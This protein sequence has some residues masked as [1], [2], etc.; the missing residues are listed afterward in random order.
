MLAT[1]CE[2]SPA[3]TYSSARLLHQARCSS[4]VNASPLCFRR[5]A[6]AVDAPSVDL[7]L[8]VSVI[9]CRLLGL[10]AFGRCFLAIRLSP[11]LSSFARV[12]QSFLARGFLGDHR[13]FKLL[14]KHN[15]ARR[16]SFRVQINEIA[17]VKKTR[18]PVLVARVSRL[19]EIDIVRIVCVKKP[20]HSS[21][22]ARGCGVTQY[23][24]PVFFR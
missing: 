12:G 6:N 1:A 3:S 7:A 17:E 14:H 15:G 16:C 8:A 20:R 13:R 19:G 18:N 5:Q 4:R 9:H 10:R 11:S 24:L 23:R 2:R 21:P 22:V